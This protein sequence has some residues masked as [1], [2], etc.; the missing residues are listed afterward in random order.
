[1]N[2]SIIVLILILISIGGA[3]F[4]I[5]PR[6]Q[7]LQALEEEIVRKEEELSKRK[8]YVVDLERKKT[9]LDQA[10]VQM[11][12]IETALPEDLPPPFLHDLVENI[13]QSSGVSLDSLQSSPPESF[14]ENSRVSVIPVQVT[15]SG[16]YDSIKR[17]MREIR[18][19][20]RLLDITSISFAP[21]SVQEQGEDSSFIP[22]IPIF[23]ASLSLQAYIN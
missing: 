5:W 11:K 1:M 21:L 2:K 14:E 22:I 12:N 13:V 9:Q 10:Q 23:S 3:V 8:S 6:Y 19:S 15:V 16:S 7:G 4:G 20:A 18:S 17:L